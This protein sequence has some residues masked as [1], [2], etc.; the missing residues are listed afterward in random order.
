[1][2]ENAF[3]LMKGR[4]RICCQE[5]QDSIER[6]PLIAVTCGILHNNCILSD[7]RYEFNDP[8]DS[9]SDDDDE[10]MHNRNPTGNQIREIIRQSLQKC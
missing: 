7:D 8:E 10:N 5:I 3:G 6:I 2:A 1:M 9:D 4:W